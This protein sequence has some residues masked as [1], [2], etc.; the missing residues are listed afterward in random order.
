MYAAGRAVG[1]GLEASFDPNGK[2]V[3]VTACARGPRGYVEIRGT[4]TNTT[5]QLADYLIDVVVKN[6]S[7][8]QVAE[9]DAAPWKVSPGTTVKWIAPTRSSFTPATTCD[10]SVVMRTSEP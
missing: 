1:R 5:T 7:G 9:G 2:G 10:L 3:A 8:T 6:H 4:A